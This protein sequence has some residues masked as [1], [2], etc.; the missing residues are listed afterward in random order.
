M[1]QEEGTTCKELI[2]QVDSARGQSEG[3]QGEG[4]AA[5]TVKLGISLESC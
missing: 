4:R 3:L 5:R 2:V 1:V